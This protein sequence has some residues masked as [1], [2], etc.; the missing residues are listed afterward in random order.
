MEGVYFR[1]SRFST[2]TKGNN[3]MIILSP[4][5]WKKLKV[6]NSE[7]IDINHAIQSY[8]DFMMCELDKE[9]EEVKE[10]VQSMKFNAA[11]H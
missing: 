5:T 2:K 3:K 4:K 1:T 6:L 8:I 10:I 11:Q 9:N 7:G